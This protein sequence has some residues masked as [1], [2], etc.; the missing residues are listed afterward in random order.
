MKKCLDDKD[1]EIREADL[2]DIFGILKQKIRMSGQEMKDLA[3]EG[4]EN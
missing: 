2:S 4:W 3:R 1:I